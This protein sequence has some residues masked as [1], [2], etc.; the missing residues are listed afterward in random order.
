MKQLMSG[1]ASKKKSG[2][3]LEGDPRQI[4]VQIIQ[5]LQDEKII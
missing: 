1:G 5:L 2:D 4:A 3:L